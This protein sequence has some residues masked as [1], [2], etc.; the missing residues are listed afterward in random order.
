MTIDLTCPYCSFSKKV[1]KE[2]IPANAKWAT[3]PRCRERFEVFSSDE[4]IALVVTKT[5]KE[6]RHQASAEETEEEFIREDAYWENRSELGLWQ[7]IYQTIKAVLFSPDAFFRKLKYKGGMK[8]PLAFGLLIGSIGAM[9]GVFWQFL[10]MTGG[11]HPIAD[12]IT[13]QFGLSLIFLVSI[14]FIP[15]AM[16]VGMFISSG[17]WHMF[18]LLLKGADHGFEGTF[19][20]VSYSQSAQIVSL[21]PVLGGWVSVI[22]QLVIQ[23]IGLKELHETTYLKV[24]LAF[25]IPVSVVVFLIL[26]A[27]TFL[28]VFL[29]Q[30]HF[31]QLL[32]F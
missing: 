21:I 2:K 18:L 26:S 32:C 19:R 15:I 20:V 13:G 28:I 3:C 16:V 4:D 17:I 24:I 8:E 9:F 7:A 5:Q 12:F 14:I 29:G 6:T 10:M 27:I 23:I 11:L 22:W 1:P 31:G 25:L 30:Q